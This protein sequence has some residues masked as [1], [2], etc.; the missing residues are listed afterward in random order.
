MLV[1]RSV[2]KHRHRFSLVLKYYFPLNVE[3]V[4]DRIKSARL[5]NKHH[6]IIKHTR[7]LV[8]KYCTPAD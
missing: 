5:A 4:Y 2:A 6:L 7:Y 8:T 1:K 3:L